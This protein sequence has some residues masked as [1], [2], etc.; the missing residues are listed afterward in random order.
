MFDY[1][2]M[3]NGPIHLLYGSGTYVRNRS[4]RNDRITS[5]PIQLLYGPSGPR[6]YVI[7]DLT[8]LRGVGPRDG[9]RT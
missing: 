1:A 7:R 4:M 8:G 9:V 6:E 3:R 5:E 2:W